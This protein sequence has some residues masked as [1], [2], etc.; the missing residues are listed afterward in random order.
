MD[1]SKWKIPMPL[2]SYSQ[3]GFLN[4]E[5]SPLTSKYTVR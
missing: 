3:N 2:E 1:N 5:A 4:P